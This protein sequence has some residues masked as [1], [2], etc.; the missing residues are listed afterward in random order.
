MKFFILY[1]CILFTISFSSEPININFKD[2]ELVEMNLN[3]YEVVISDKV[4]D[5]IL[6]RIKKSL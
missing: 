5:L 6:D 1:F 2:F 4:V 3:H